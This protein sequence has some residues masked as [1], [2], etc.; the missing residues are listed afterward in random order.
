MRNRADKLL[1]SG[2]LVSALL[3]ALLWLLQRS[4]DPFG[5]TS[6]SVAVQEGG[7]RRPSSF[8]TTPSAPERRPL[9][10]PGQAPEVRPLEPTYLFGRLR[11]D[12]EAVAGGWVGVSSADG[13]FGR[14]CA[15][16]F[17]GRFRLDRVPIE[18]LTLTIQFPVDT[19]RIV[20]APT[21]DLSPQPDQPLELE[22]DWHSKQVNLRVLD[23]ERIGIPAR[24]EVRGPHLVA[25]L[26]TDQDGTAKLVVI[27]SGLF[28]FHARAR[29]GLEGE[30]EIELDVADDLTS[31]VVM[32]AR[33][34][35]ANS[36]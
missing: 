13:T 30:A 36:D 35:A 19:R 23:P 3:L 27:D 28:Q 20:L 21:L 8:A 5:S 11:L 12:G 10:T 4:P 2:G 15:L 16:D 7:S 26:E 9:E 31:V 14:H 32:V 24:V 1:A 17:E 33:P 25:S 29:R 34:E 6:R 22:L 18:A